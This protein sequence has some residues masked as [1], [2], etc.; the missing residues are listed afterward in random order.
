VGRQARG[1]GERQHGYTNRAE[2]NGRG[3]G[4]QADGGGEEGR[5]AKP[6]HHRGR[7]GHWRGEPGRTF[8]E[9]TQRK[10]NQQC[11]QAPVAGE[12]RD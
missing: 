10:C 4:Q 5:K 11:L 9:A 7:H 1:A 8:Y 6:G 2:C 12:A 3:V